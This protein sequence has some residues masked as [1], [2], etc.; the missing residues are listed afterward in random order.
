MDALAAAQRDAPRAARR[1]LGP[2]KHSGAFLLARAD[3]PPGGFD[4]WARAG[5]SAP[6]ALIVAGCWWLLREVEAAHV[7][8]GDVQ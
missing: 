3:E 4:P 8:P 1:G 2:P 5:P 6:E 7:T